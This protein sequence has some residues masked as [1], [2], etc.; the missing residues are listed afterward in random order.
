MSQSRI[1]VRA[2]RWLAAAGALVVVFGFA[3]ASASADSSNPYP[4]V[5]RLTALG[6]SVPAGMPGAP[7]P[8]GQIN[9][10][11]AQLVVDP[12]L[13]KVDGVQ[14]VLNM[15][16]TRQ[17]GPGSPAP[18]L[19]VNLNR[20]TNAQLDSQD[21]DYFLTPASGISFTFDQP[22]M[23][24][25]KIKT[26]GVASIAMDLAY[27]AS[28][29][30]TKFPCTLASGG[31]SFEQ[32][33]SGRLS[34]S[35]FKFVSGSSPF[36]GTI[37]KRPVT[38]T[39]YYDP[40]CRVVVVGASS[41]L[42]GCQGTETLLAAD[43][44]G[45]TQWVAQNDY[46]DGFGFQAALA[47]TATPSRETTHITESVIPGTAMPPPKASSSGAT[48]ILRTTGNAFMTG[49]ATFTSKRAPGVKTGL[50]CVDLFGQR[51]SFTRKV[52]H[53]RLVANAPPLTAAFDTG[54][55]PLTPSKSKM[56]FLVYT[57]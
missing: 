42:P 50:R 13:I 3:A 43:S 15:S 31:K 35:S 55:V 46:D 11:T 7:A 14:Y 54:G 30:Q 18:Y 51:H 16:V 39:L 5:S 25:A 41:R 19:D 6:I 56:I 26:T 23:G 40:G 48:A 49:T 12:I 17:G 32:V 10:T 45:A 22:T 1:R 34:F 47:A 57:S 38:A 37:T 8:N 27:K 2:R 44:T 33:S 21:H 28:G 36:F 9:F 20:L 4:L 52:Y 24:S 53:G 29:K